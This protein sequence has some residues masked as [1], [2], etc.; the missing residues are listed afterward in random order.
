MQSTTLPVQVRPVERSEVPEVIKFLRD[1]FQNLARRSPDD[2]RP[3][4]EYRWPNGSEKPSLGFALWSGQEIVGFLG[5]VYAERPLG[6]RLIKTCNLSTWYVRQDFRGSALKLLTAVLAGRE[7][8][9]TNLTASPEARRI[10]E[11]LGFQT[12]DQCKWVYLAWRFWR[13]MLRSGPKVVSSP[14]QIAE[15]LQG[16]DRQ[17][18][19]DHLSY[20]LKHYLLRSGSDYSYLVLKRRRFPGDVAFSRSPLKK[21]RLLWYPCME[22]LHLGNL[23]LALRHW[24]HLMATILRRERVLAVVVAERFLGATP[25]RGIRLEHR[26]YLLARE[27]LNATIDSL[28]SELAVYPF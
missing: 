6:G 20:R 25:P 24:E 16:D 2:L 18:L 5:V 10:M 4:F 26:N 15:V 27:P 22:V 3:L 23:K 8:S 14:E 13:T 1:G 11:A 28:Y 17:L 12:I 21:V 7:Y 9:V 19:C